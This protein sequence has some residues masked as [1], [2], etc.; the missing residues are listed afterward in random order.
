MPGTD[1]TASARVCKP[2]ERETKTTGSVV[3]GAE[4]NALASNV[5]VL[6]VLTLSTDTVLTLSCYQRA[7]F[8]RTCAREVR[9]LLPTLPC[10]HFRHPFKLGEAVHG[11]AQW[12]RLGRPK[13]WWEGIRGCTPLRLWSPEP[14][15]ALTRPTSPSSYAGCPPALVLS[16]MPG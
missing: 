9:E 4:W 2:N 11:E 16:R 13:R 10:Q 15:H 7:R 14:W 12:L 8:K 6:R 5:R 3:F 1:A